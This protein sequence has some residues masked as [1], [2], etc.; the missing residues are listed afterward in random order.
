[1]T[2]T[3]QLR[4]DSEFQAL[5]PSLSDDEL[6]QLEANL[7]AEGC[8]NPLVVWAETG[9]LLDG[10]NQHG[11]CEEHGLG[12]EVQALSLPD[13][14][15]ATNWIIDH[16]LGRRNLPEEQQSYLRGQRYNREK[17]AGHGATV[18]HSDGQHT[19]KRVAAAY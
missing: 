2:T 17:T 13:R 14:D 8:R 19:A 18:P 15:A 6:A 1:M 10:H 12:F 3:I 9:L 16:Q 5:I 11:I 4:I 7:L